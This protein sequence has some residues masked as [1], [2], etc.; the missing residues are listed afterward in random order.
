MPSVSFDFRKSNFI[1]SSTLSTNTSSTSFS[2]LSSVTLPTAPIKPVLIG[3]KTGSFIL[4][5]TS[6]ASISASFQIKRNTT[7]IASFDLSA[8][9]LAAT[10]NDIIVPASGFNTTDLS[11]S[12]ATYSIEWKVN[13]ASMLLTADDVIFYAL[14][15]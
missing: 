4:D 8:S 14:E 2:V 15:F 5:G 12:T 6:I 13:G 11:P 1:E 10:N 7:V 9:D 3:F